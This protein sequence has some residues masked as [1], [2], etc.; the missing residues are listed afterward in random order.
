MTQIN[1]NGKRETAGRCPF[2][3]EGR[4]T[5]EGCALWN[6]DVR[7]CALSPYSLHLIV[8][9][10]VCDASVEIWKARRDAR[11]MRRDGNESGNL[12]P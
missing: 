7:A 11:R 2:R 8:K 5:M 12:S 4:C 10:A 3:E 9:T 1:V 6:E